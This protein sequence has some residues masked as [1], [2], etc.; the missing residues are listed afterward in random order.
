M[1]W[2]NVLKILCGF[3]AVIFTIT[4]IGRNIENAA[5]TYRQTEMTGIDYSCHSLLYG[6]SGRQYYI[7]SSATA[8][9]T[10]VTTAV[11]NWNLSS[12]NVSFSEATSQ[13]QGTIKFY[14]GTISEPN[15]PGQT[16]MYSSSTTYNPSTSSW[17]NAKIIMS[18]SLFPSMSAVKQRGTCAH[19]FGHAIGL[20]HMLRLSG[21]T[22]YFDATW[23]MTP[24][25]SRTGYTVDAYAADVVDAHLY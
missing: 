13:G 8:Y 18:S 20:N 14:S 16:I 1:S 25:A 10:A 12:S 11:S 21:T 22:A 24:Y 4:S 5:C 23:I 2:K 7:D 19:E 6:V 15:S 3:V 9:R 17:P